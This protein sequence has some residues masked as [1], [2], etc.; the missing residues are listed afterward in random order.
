MSGVKFRLRDARGRL[1]VLWALLPLVFSLLVL[2]ANVR[3]ATTDALNL[4]YQ[5][6]DQT[7]HSGWRALS[8]EDRYHDA[9]AMIGAYLTGHA[10]LDRFQRA[11]LHFHA[12]Q[13]LAFAGDAAGALKH[14]SSAR[15]DPEPPGSPVRWNDYVAATI[16]FLQ[17]ERG[18]LLAARERI[19]RGTAIDGEIPNLNVVDRLISHYNQ[20]YRTAYLANGDAGLLARTIQFPEGR[21]IG[22][23]YVRE[24]SVDR[25]LAYESAPW[26]FAGLARGALQIAAGHEAQLE[27]SRGGLRDLSAL[28]AID[29]NALQF[30]NLRD[31]NLN[32]GHLTNIVHLRGLR[33]LRLSGNP[34]TDAGMRLLTNFPQLTYI[35]LSD[36]LAGDESIAGLASLRL[37][38]QAGLY[39]TR[40]TDRA[41]ASLAALPQLRSLDL[42]QTKITDEGLANLIPAAGLESLRFSDCNVTDRGLA[43]VS[44]LGELKSLEFSGIHAS[45]AGLSYIAHLSKLQVLRVDRNPFTDAGVAH[46]IRLPAVESITLSGRFT[47]SALNHLGT[48]RTLKKL[49]VQNGAFTAAGLR[50]LAGLPQLEELSI[51]T[52]VLQDSSQGVPALAQIRSLKRLEIYDFPIGRQDLKALAALPSLEHA[53]LGAPLRFEEMDVLKNCQSLRSVSYIAGREREK[54]TR[55]LRQFSGMRQLTRLELPDVP[56]EGA[57]FAHLAELIKLERFDYG[58]GMTDEGLKHLAGM[59]SLKELYLKNARVTDEGLRHLS[60]LQKLEWLQIGGDITDHGLVHLKDLKSLRT[61]SLETQSVSQEQVRWLKQELPRL[62]R[63]STPLERAFTG[64]DRTISLVGQVAPDFKTTTLNGKSFQLSDQRGKVVLVY[65]WATWCAPCV[66]K[67]DAR[68]QMHDELTARYGDRFVMISLS[69]DWDEPKLRTH[70]QR[71]GEAWTQARIGMATK[72]ADDYRVAGAGHYFVIGQ[73]GRVLSDAD[74]L[75]QIK[76]TVC[77]ALEGDRN[78]RN[79]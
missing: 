9:A 44:A 34:L 40:I 77:L 26:E 74:T 61:L 35:N 4:G 17:R 38:Q 50:H 60:G 19:A 32:D 33:A 64:E 51:E 1:Y 48:I 24:T 46:L 78:A 52:D 12:A 42:M 68:K 54:V 65:F 67:T 79:K 47:D 25:T 56:F 71:T 53:G 73:D 2:Q 57:E 13:M 70:L 36:T 30:L 31:L 45:D 5:Q 6:F 58:G 76:A 28:K 43:F 62:G 20:P 37:L 11:N 21:V 8:D 39:R 49:S 69:R 22:S 23:V 14:L 75:E 10:S 41:L 59:K 55:G 18:Q 16:A 66:Q 15:L 29:A 72:I 27:V 63:L 7:P 3:G